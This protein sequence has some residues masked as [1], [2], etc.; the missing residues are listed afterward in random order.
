MEAGK[1]VSYD[2]DI[3]TGW[4][5]LV[6]VREKNRLRLYLDGKECATS[7]L[8]DGGDYPLANRVPLFIGKGAQS[9]FSG[10]LADLRVYGG[11][12]SAGQVAELYRTV[13]K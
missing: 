5:H 4:K 3:G 1:N 6:A 9:N 11:A 13:S 7:D 12:L 10:S 8:F 2:D